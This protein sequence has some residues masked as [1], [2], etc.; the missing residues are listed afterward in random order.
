MCYADM[1]LVSHACVFVIQ[2]CDLAT[3]GVFWMIIHEFSSYSLLVKERD[4]ESEIFKAMFVLV[5]CDPSCIEKEQYLN[6]LMMQM[7]LLQSHK[8]LA[9]LQIRFY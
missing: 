9:V 3:L 2:C 6:V 4:D 7:C 1:P 8:I 5:I